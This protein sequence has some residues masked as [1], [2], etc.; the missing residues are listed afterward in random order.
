[1]IFERNHDTLLIYP[2]FYLLEDGCIH[3]IYIY[4]YI[5]IYT[6]Y[7]PLPYPISLPIS[8]LLGAVP[9]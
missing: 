9:N 3:I 6:W 5:Y 8:L 1:M 2:F 7:P 4:M